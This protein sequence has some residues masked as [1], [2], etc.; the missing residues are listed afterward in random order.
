MPETAD[1]ESDAGSVDSQRSVGSLAESITTIMGRLSEFEQVLEIA[2][3]SLDAGTLVV[4]GS[5]GN[6]EVRDTPARDTANVNDE[7]LRAR[8]Q[9]ELIELR[10]QLEVAENGRVLAEQRAQEAEEKLWA[11]ERE[12]D[13]MRQQWAAHGSRAKEAEDRVAQVEAQLEINKALVQ[14]A[15]S[16]LEESESMQQRAALIWDKKLKELADKLAAAEVE[17]EALEKRL[18]SLR[19]LEHATSVDAI[20]EMCE[21]GKALALGDDSRL[22]QCLKQVDTKRRQSQRLSLDETN[23][24]TVAKFIAAQSFRP[25]SKAAQAEFAQDMADLMEL[26]L[27]LQGKM[28]TGGFSFPAKALDDAQLQDLVEKLRTELEG[29]IVS[30]SQLVRD[31]GLPYFIQ[32]LRHGLLKI[33][34]THLERLFQGRRT[35]PELAAVHG[36][37]FDA[38]MAR[39]KATN[40]LADAH[41]LTLIFQQDQRLIYEGVAV[42][43]SE[44]SPVIK[45]EVAGTAGNITW[46]KDLELSG[47]ALM[48]IAKRE[49]MKADA[50]DMV[51]RLY[52]I[53]S[54]AQQ[55][56]T[57]FCGNIHYFVEGA[58]REMDAFRQD[59]GTITPQMIMHALV[60][61]V[62]LKYGGESES[63]WRADKRLRREWDDEIGRWNYNAVKGKVTGLVHELAIFQREH[64][65]YLYDCHPLTKQEHREE[66]GGAT[67]F[68]INIFAG[69]PTKSA[70]AFG[71][72]AQAARLAANGLPADTCWAWAEKGRRCSRGAYCPYQHPR[73]AANILDPSVKKEHISAESSPDNRVSEEP[74]NTVHFDSAY[75]SDDYA[76]ESGDRFEFDSTT[77]FGNTVFTLVVHDPVPLSEKACDWFT[78][79]QDELF[80]DVYT[81]VPV[82]PLASTSCQH[83]FGPA[84]LD[85]VGAAGKSSM[86]ASWTLPTSPQGKS[87]GCSGSSCDHSEVENLDSAMTTNVSVLSVG[88]VVCA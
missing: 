22:S 13:D 21:S 50:L 84:R 20:F 61:P 86:A 60:L 3:S 33:G 36:D 56:E 78:F 68:E 25:A 38:E 32:V 46:A 12:M 49:L 59:Y 24:D 45:N 55:Y 23:I 75:E 43:T 69:S 79:S 8:L 54:L 5:S 82:E 57:R 18:Q 7:R 16:R 88:S 64:Y 39:R 30:S 4:T 15:Q 65:P 83:D 19:E 67:A 63:Q 2:E 62:L 70:S 51:Q 44:L 27:S 85:A 11:R 66:N 17:R 37:A 71:A 28:G 26:N 42:L 31:G 58:A 48:T 72:S 29:K 35:I 74:V 14:E 52:D 76:P 9:R 41:Q 53:I 1:G 40:K 10:G 47:Y 34:R 80:G 6:S 73:D 81:S 87:V 77:L